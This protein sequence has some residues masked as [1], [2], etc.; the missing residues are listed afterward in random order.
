MEA[1][2]AGDSGVSEDGGACLIG[3]LFGD[4]KEKGAVILLK[5]GIDYCADAIVRFASAAS[6]EDELNRH[7]QYPRK[8]DDTF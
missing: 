1:V 3:R 5:E 8:T 2:V 7:T 4:E 6:A